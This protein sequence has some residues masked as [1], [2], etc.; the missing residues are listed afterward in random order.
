MKILMNSFLLLLLLAPFAL[1]Q[2]FE[3]GTP[4]ELKGKSTVYLNTYGDVENYG[5]IKGLI[6]KAKI[7]VKFVSEDDNPEVILPFRS[8]SK[9]QINGALASG[10]AVMIAREQVSTGHGYI[11]V[12]SPR[13][14]KLRILIDFESVRDKWGEKKPGTKFANQ[15]VA[16]YKSANGQ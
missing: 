3:Y 14:T 16:A 12:P 4:I 9:E 8:G 15:F 11:A 6:E 7:G 1:S 2:D 13:T 10:N 5:R